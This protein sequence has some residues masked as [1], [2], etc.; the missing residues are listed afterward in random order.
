[1]PGVFFSSSSNPL[2]R[3]WTEATV[4]WSMTRTLPWPS[5]Y[6]ASAWA[7]SRPP[8]TLSLATC[9]TILPLRAAMSTVKTGIPAR[10]ASWRLG[11]MASESQGAAMMAE[12]RWATKSSICEACLAGSISQAVTMRSRPRAAASLR[13]ASSSSL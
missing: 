2:I 1:M 13:I 5:R 6:R 11:P 7:A 3:S 4:G 10:S 9:E 12:T 8:W